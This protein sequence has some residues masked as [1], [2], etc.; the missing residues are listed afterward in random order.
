M[1]AHGV[2]WRRANL[3]E[4]QEACDG[5]RKRVA[6]HAP[7]YRH[8]DDMEWEMGRFKNKTKF[9]FHARADRPTETGI[10][11]SLVR[12]RG[13]TLLRWHDL[14]SRNI[15]VHARPALRGRD[16][17]EERMYGCVS[18]ISGSDYWCASALRRSDEPT[19]TR[20]TR[21][22]RPQ[23]LSGIQPLSKDERLHASGSPG[24]YTNFG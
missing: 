3:E 24:E 19:E 7:E 4:T 9:L 23:S 21:G 22:V 16:D 8:V 1:S 6:D 13:R 15:C 20:I 18:S 5:R 2:W 11:A 12:P 17:H 10:R 14:R